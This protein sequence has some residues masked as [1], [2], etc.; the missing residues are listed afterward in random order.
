MAAAHPPRTLT[1]TLT[2]HHGLGNDFLVVLDPPEQ[3]DLA[4][5][6]RHLCDR[7]RGVGADG[8]LAGF[9]TDVADARMVLHNADGSVAEMSG[10]GIRCLAQAVVDAGWCDEGSVAIA[11]DVGDRVVD[12]GPDD[13]HGLRISRTS[14]GPAKVVRTEGKLAV[15][16]T[17]NPHL[18]LQVDDPAAIDM[19]ALGAEHADVNVEVIRVDDRSN[20]TMRVYERGVGVTE[21]CGTGS[22]AVAAA[23]LAWGLTGPQVVVHNPGGPLTVELDLADEAWLTGPSVFVGRVEVVNAWL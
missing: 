21:A 17:G 5:A 12:V 2:K 20:I 10:N 19:D 15:V 9:R 14:M 11:T 4:A 7:R 13:G 23:A 6:A 3:M 18:V 8:F 22:C 1:L 16:D